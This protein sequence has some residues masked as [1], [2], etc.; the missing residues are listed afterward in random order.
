MSDFYAV[1]NHVLGQALAA[2]NYQMEDNPTHQSRGLFRYGKQLAPDKYVFIEF[3][4]LYHPQSELSRFR[5]NLLKNNHPDA[6]ATSPDAVEKTLSEVIWHDFG[7]RV[8]PFADHWWMY[9]HPQDLAYELLEAGKLLF[10][11]GVPWLEDTIE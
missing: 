1:L 7:A 4:T 6:R 11:Y 10:G 2:G 3:Q 8:L 9:K 5:V